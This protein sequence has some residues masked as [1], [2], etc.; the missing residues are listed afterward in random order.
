MAA[1]T[2][3]QTVSSPRDDLRQRRDRLASRAE[4]ADYLGVPPATLDRWAYARTGPPY[5][6][7]GRHA[8]YRWIDVDNWLAQQESGGG[9][10]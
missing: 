6:I 7:I 1:M 5:K 4:V 8:R 2:F 3:R 10:A 9:A